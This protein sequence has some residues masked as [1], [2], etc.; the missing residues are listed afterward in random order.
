M[1]KVKEKERMGTAGFGSIL[2]VWTVGQLVSYYFLYFLSLISTP[3]DNEWVVRYGDV[4]GCACYVTRDIRLKWEFIDRLPHRFV[5]LR[6]NRRMRTTESGEKSYVEITWTWWRE[7]QY[8]SGCSCDLCGMIDTFA[9]THSTLT[10]NTF[11][12]YLLEERNLRIH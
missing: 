5:M 9:Q 10:L 2:G 11:W 8:A 3:I 12:E 7:A 1:I 6:N 4:K